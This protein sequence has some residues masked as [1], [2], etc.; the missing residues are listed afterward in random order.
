VTL[1]HGR[2]RMRAR[3]QNVFPGAAAAVVC[4][5]G[6]AACWDAASLNVAPSDL[7]E[8]PGDPDAGADAT[9]SEGGAPATDAAGDAPSPPPCSPP[10]ALCGP[11]CTDRSS[12]PFN[13]GTCGKSCALPPAPTCDGPIASSFTPGACIVGACAF[14]K[15]TI[16]CSATG[17]QCTA[18]VCAGC[19]AGLQDNDLDGTCTPDCASAALDC[20]GN[21]ACSDASGTPAC[22]CLP[23]FTGVQCENNIDDC[24]GAPC[25]NGG[26]CVDGANG[27]TCN[28]AGG[29][30][31][32][33]CE[34]LPTPTFLWLDASDPA[35]LTQDVT[36]N[37]TEWR[38]KSGLARHATVPGGSGAPTFTGNVVNG[39]PAIRFEGDTIRLQTVAVPTSAEMTIFVVFD[40]VSP[41]T[42][43]TL[44]NQ[45]HDTYFSIRKS[46][47]CGGNGNLNFHIQ[48]NN[49]APLQPITLNSWRVL[50]A[51]R[52]GNVSTMYYDPAG[53]TSFTGDTLTG[54]IDVPITIGNAQALA[55]S[56][57]GY[58][59]EIRAYASPLDTTT[60]AAV[61]LALKTKYAIP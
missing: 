7:I 51:M 40:M 31:G 56:M 32:P 44:I 8:L 12:D 14:P 50:T 16:D 36:N 24:V 42:W 9:P 1:H 47:C 15:T 5:L 38:D 49:A 26:Q 25:K 57:G 18:G 55:Q 4:A 22:V 28:C 37:V 2:N 3:S 23:G 45:S 29:F 6:L 13:C 21:G 60:R 20:N 17:R 10:L 59:A 58:I 11:I 52:Q 54:G 30:T 19:I 27:F 33:T 53:A 48:N 46:D 43:G 34:T 39:L 41:Q 35:T 61:E